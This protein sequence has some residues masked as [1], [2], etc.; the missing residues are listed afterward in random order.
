MPKKLKIEIITLKARVLA[1]TVPT[2]WKSGPVKRLLDFALTSCEGADVEKEYHF[3]NVK[4][5]VQIP[6]QAN[7]SSWIVRGDRLEMTEGKGPEIRS[8]AQ[9]LND[10]YKKWNEIERKIERTEEE[11][12]TDV[13]TPEQA[14]K[15]CTSQIIKWTNETERLRKFLKNQY[16]AKV[17]TLPFPTLVRN[18]WDALETEE[19]RSTFLA[20]GKALFLKGHIMK[21]NDIGAKKNVLIV[22][23]AVTRDPERDYDLT[24][25]TNPL[26][27]LFEV[28]I[29]SEENDKK[30][31]PNAGLEDFMKRQR[32]P[33]ERIDGTPLHLDTHSNRDRLLTEWLLTLR[34]LFLTQLACCYASILTYRGKE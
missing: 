19:N 3:V 1:V 34:S 30:H 25:K 9:S 21:F 22:L 18:A 5:K 23:G 8:N 28:L 10:S 27:D 12:D 13:I 29:R 4:T 31:V 17:E 6:N 11:E 15:E 14:E 24:G 7:I 33:S 16:D 20:R 26:L 32:M 2:K